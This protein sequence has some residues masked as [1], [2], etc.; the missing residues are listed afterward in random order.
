MPES[1]EGF[2]ELQRLRHEVEDLKGITSALLRTQPNLA[3]GIVRDLTD[4]PALGRILLLTDGERSQN[5]IMGILKTEGLRGA[6]LAGVSERVSKLVHDYGL[7][8]FDRR[9]KAGNIYRR[10]VLDG[11]LQIS[12]ALERQSKK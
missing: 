4:D 3:K 5:E 9:T 10:T 6:S 11:S 8:A 12:R 2:A 1:I 7:I